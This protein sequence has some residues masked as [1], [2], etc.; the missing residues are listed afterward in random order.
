MAN[1][2]GKMIKLLRK[3][4]GVT[5]D[6]LAVA[7]NISNQSV[8]K[9]ENGL[10]NPDITYIPIIAKFF[11]VSIETLFLYEPSASVHE[12]QNII[13]RQKELLLTDDIDSI[14]GLWEDL[15]LKYPNDYRIQKELIISMCLKSD[16]TLFDKIMNH[17]IEVLRK[18]K[19]ASI[20]N[21]ILSALKTLYVG[22][23]NHNNGIYTETLNES[24]L[25]NDLGKVLSQSEINVLFEN[26]LKKS[27]LGK[28]VLIVDDAKFMRTML[29]EILIRGGY[30]VVGE[31]AN[32]Y[33]AIEA[34]NALEPNIILMDI[35]MPSLDGLSAY[36]QILPLNLSLCVV[37]CSAMAYHKT[38]I[39]AIK[40][41]ASYF[42]KKPFKP[43][44]L[45]SV[46]DNLF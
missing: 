29:S 24:A 13:Q 8:S 37:M 7:L 1:N 30:E 39:K 36:E 38:V 28:K 6:D 19:D 26:G 5:Q 45:L 10:A 3:E 20:E 46:M 16:K 33:E 2:I 4:Q 42:I 21:E 32:G 27:S 15:H 25:R 14:I 40:L 11:Q 31:A 23:K 22:D 34:V 12:Y 18:N 35:S 44:E 9:W 41:G 17:V 43:D